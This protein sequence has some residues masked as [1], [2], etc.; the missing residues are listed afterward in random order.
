MAAGSHKAKKYKRVITRKK[1]EQQKHNWRKV[2]MC[3][4]QREKNNNNSNNNCYIAKLHAT[5]T[6]HTND[7]QITAAFPAN[8]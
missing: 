5:S 6:K 7:Q 4:C 8:A 3:Q 1:E 2:N